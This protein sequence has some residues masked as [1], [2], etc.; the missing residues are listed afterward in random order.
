MATIY[1]QA[2]N[3]SKSF[4]DL[5]IFSDISLGLFQYQRTAIIAKNGTGKS[6]LLNILTGKD[7]PDT[8]KVTLRNDVKVGYLPQNPDL[9]EKATILENV[10]G[11]D[12]EIST[13]I[14]SYEKA[15]A[16]RSDPRWLSPPS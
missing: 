2:E 8:G 4:G 1:L 7:S 6:T 3:L 16:R 13:T 14:R 5:T 11:A 12:D 15:L 9:N 10:F